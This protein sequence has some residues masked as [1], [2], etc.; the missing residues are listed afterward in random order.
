MY[1]SQAIT[2]LW[3]AWRNSVGRGD[4]ERAHEVLHVEPVGAAGARTLLLRQPDLFF[5]DLGELVEGR[6]AAIAGVDRCRQGAVVGHAAPVFLLFL[7]PDSSRG[8]ANVINR[9]IT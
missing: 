1:R 3:S 5:G 9:I 8:K 7:V 6:D 2:A 4:A